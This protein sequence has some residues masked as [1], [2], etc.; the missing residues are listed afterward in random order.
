MV[1]ME[2]K[3][4]ESRVLL[5]DFDRRH[6]VL[7]GG[8]LALDEADFDRFERKPGPVEPSWERVFDLERWTPDWDTPPEEQSI[9]AVFWELRLD[10]VRKVQHFIA[11]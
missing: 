1:Q 3:I 9:Q 2:L 11:K 4:E 10:Q 6:T 7:G 5:S 8:Y